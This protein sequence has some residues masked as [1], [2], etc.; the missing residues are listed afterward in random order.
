MKRK[1]KYIVVLLCMLI[2]SAVLPCKAFAKEVLDIDKMGAISVT[3]ENEGVAVPDGTL[4]CYRVAEVIKDDVN[5]SFDYTEE[6]KAC[7]I[8]LEDI[9]SVYLAERLQKYTEGKP[10]ERKKI[11]EKG[12]VEFTDLDAGLY[13]LVQE[14]AAEGYYPVNSFL[15]LLPTQN[16]ESWENHVDATPK[17]ELEKKHEPEVPSTHHDSKLPQT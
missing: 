12:Y 2:L 3:M 8:S 13:L 16:G 14:E 17:I 4:T 5:Y 9:Q 11:N 7:P 15:V 6:W 10:Y 1:K